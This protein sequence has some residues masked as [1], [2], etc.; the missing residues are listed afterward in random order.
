MDNFLSNLF[1]IFKNNKSVKIFK[2]LKNLFNFKNKKT[3]KLIHSF[4]RLSILINIIT[5]F[6]LYI[7]NKYYIS[8]N[9]LFLAKELISLSTVTISFSII[10]AIV[11]ENYFL[12]Q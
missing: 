6:I 7:F 4:G 2:E 5:I 11:F 10:C 8:I 12:K 1:P 3:Y 9:L